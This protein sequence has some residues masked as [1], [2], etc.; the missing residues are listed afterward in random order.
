MSYITFSLT[1]LERLFSTFASMTLKLILALFIVMLL[2]RAVGKY[3]RPLLH[4][5]SVTSDHL[6]KMQQQ[7]DQMNRGQQQAPEAKQRR[8][9]KKD[10]DYI[11]YEEVK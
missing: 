3:V 6:R 10:G 4:L 1:H 9:V 2:L 11:D 7:M 5:T 8:R